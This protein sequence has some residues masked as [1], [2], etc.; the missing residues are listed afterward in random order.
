MYHG[1]PMLRF[2]LL[3]LAVFLI[4]GIIAIAALLRIHP[5]RRRLIIAVATLC[6]LMWLFLP[7]LNARTDFSR[8]VR[9]TLGPPWFAWLCFTLIYCA[10]LLLI[11][12]AWLPFRRKPFA[13]FARWPSRIFLLGTLVAVV[14]GVYTALV[15]LD[16]ERVP[17]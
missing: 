12:I 9:A 2:V 7:L 17:V 16:V 1:A 13:Q 4:L 5:R 10:V 11:A 15:P 6:N 8:F 3:S 14:V